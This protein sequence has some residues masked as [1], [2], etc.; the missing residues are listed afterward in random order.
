M[1]YS[2]LA[3]IKVLVKEPLDLEE[4]TFIEELELTALINRAKDK[5][6]AIVHN[7]YEDYFETDE[8][9]SLTNG[10]AEYDLPYDIYANKIRSISYNDGSTKYEIKRYRGKLADISL[11]DDNDYYQY[12]LINPVGGYK[13]KLLPASRET[14]QENVTISYLRNANTLVSA[15]DECD[16][17][18][19]LNFIVAQTQGFCLAKENGGVIPAAKQEEIDREEAL[20]VKTL[21][22]RVPDEN[23]EIQMDTEIYGE[24]A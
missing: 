1:I 14:S 9:L 22:D 4:E 12:R 13:I 3:E 15:T 19:A 6:E 2:T 8:Y 18:E 20:L 24:H 21:S 16:I 17:P 10:E 11:I 5:A 23:T 7:I